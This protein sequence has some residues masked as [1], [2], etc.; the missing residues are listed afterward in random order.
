MVNNI[1][2]VEV[3]VL[4]FFFKI[5]RCL[6]FLFLSEKI[7]V[8]VVEFPRRFWLLSLKNVRA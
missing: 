8:S 3:K 2:P 5:N 4:V 7:L 6:I 1:D